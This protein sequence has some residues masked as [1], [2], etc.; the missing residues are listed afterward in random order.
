MSSFH[1]TD[2]SQKAFLVTGG[3]GF[4]GS[5]IVEYLLSH[6]AGKVRVLD[7]LS[8]G[9]QS[10][11]DLFANHPN[12]EFM[13]GDI[14][15]TETCA[16]AC[17]GI[18]HVTHQAALGSV[19]RS[20]K[21]PV[22]S[23]DVNIGGFVNMITAAK[24]AGVAT[25]VYASSSSV[26][27]DEPNLPKIE[28]KTGNLLSPYAVT[29]MTNELYA[30]VYHRLYG[31]NVAGLRYFNVFGQRQDPNGPYAAVIPLFVTGILNQT[32]VYING[33]GEQ[34]RDFTYVANAVQANIR[35]MLSTNPS[36]FGQAYN[37]A[38]GNNYTVNFLFQSIASLL[39][40]NHTATYRQP[41]EGDIRD[42]LADIS[43][44]NTLLGYTPTQQFMDGLKITVNY[45]KVLY[46]Q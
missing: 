44:A 5:H 31:M 14:R 20:V 12:F 25:F 46:T 42:S 17:E 15:S 19:P 24:D 3:A 16:K 21:D 27:G 40:I 11:I 45:F 18:T 26:Y 35:A 22:T 4:I 37:V 33:D 13:L 34:T 32:T 30:N 7:N 43:K 29:K 1:T 41:R 9:L 6:G 23:N 36:S 28:S 10:N 2:I 39:G 8:T 38:T